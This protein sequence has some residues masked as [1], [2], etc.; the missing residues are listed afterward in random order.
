MYFSLFLAWLQ[1][2]LGQELI[3]VLEE[4]REDEIARA[5][6]EAQL[7]HTEQL[8]STE[9]SKSAMLHSQL[10]TA[11]NSTKFYESGYNTPDNA[12]VCFSATNQTLNDNQIAYVWSLIMAFLCMN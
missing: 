5:S 3:K 8:L 6:L 4:A 10:A 1:S 9:R 7:N 12:T 11:V 2:V